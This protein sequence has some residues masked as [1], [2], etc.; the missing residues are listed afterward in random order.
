MSFPK[1]DQLHDPNSQEDWSSPPLTLNPGE[2]IVSATVTVVDSSDNP[3]LDTDLIIFGVSW[4]SVGGN[5]WEITFWAS[6]GTPGAVYFIRF[7]FQTDSV[8]FRSFDRTRQLRC[9]QT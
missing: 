3:I 6:G 9:R 4:G 5:D 7:R 2:S 8:P 1:W